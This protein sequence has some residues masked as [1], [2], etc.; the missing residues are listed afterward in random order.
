M[1]RLFLILFAILISNSIFA[2]SENYKSAFHPKTKNI[3]KLCFQLID[4]KQK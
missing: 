2:Q 3:D 1:K 4:E